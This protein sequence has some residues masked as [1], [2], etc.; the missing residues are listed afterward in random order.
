MTAISVL[1][2]SVTIVNLT[3]VSAAKSILLDW[4]DIINAEYQSVVVYRNATN[5]RSTAVAIGTATKASQYVDNN[6]TTG[7][8]YY[9]WVRSKNI[10]GYETGAWNPVGATAGLV[11]TA[12]TVDIADVSFSASTAY[13]SVS[14]LASAL[15]TA[16]Y[17]TWQLGIVKNGNFTVTDS[18]ANLRITGIMGVQIRA[19]LTGTDVIDIDY[20]LRLHNV[21]DNTYDESWTYTNVWRF[22]SGGTHYSMSYFPV[23]LVTSAALTAAKVYEIQL[24]VML[25]QTSGTPL[26]SGSEATVTTN[27]MFFKEEK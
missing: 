12:A 4:D 27:R 3:G 10:F 24:D 23:N 16:I 1:S 2:P 26:I 18:T 11:V 14:M 21:T 20:R 8:T 7:T 17:G 9:Y 19:A 5:D 15:S 6:I 25:I 22:D 13:S